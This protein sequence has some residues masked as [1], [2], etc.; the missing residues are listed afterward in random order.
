[1]AGTLGATFHDVATA[2]LEKANRLVMSEHFDEAISCIA[3]D[4]LMRSLRRGVEHVAKAANVSTLD[5]FGRLGMDQ[6]DE[7]LG[8][9]AACQV[10]ALTEW[11]A[12]AAHAG[13]LPGSSLVPDDGQPRQ[14]PA[15]LGRAA[16]TLQ[17][18]T[19]LSA[20][21]D[22]LANEVTDWMTALARCREL[23]DNAQD[24]ARG[25]RMRRLKRAIAALLVVAVAAGAGVYLTKRSLAHARVDAVIALGSCDVAQMDASDLARASSAQHDAVERERQRCE[26]EREQARLAQEVQQRADEKRKA[27]ERE[28]RRR[29]EACTRLGRNFANGSLDDVD[30]KLIGE[31]RPLFDRLASGRL[32]VNDVAAG[33]EPPCPDT[34]TGKALRLAYAR[35]VLVSVQQWLRRVTPSR[36]ACSA[37]VEHK[38]ALSAH[39]LALLAGHIE[40]LSKRAVM[41]GKEPDVRRF[42]TLCTLATQIADS[43]GGNCE[44]VQKL[45]E[46]L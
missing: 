36:D 21:L 10:T 13:G 34:E 38:M 33:F 26:D 46:K 23:I 11:R 24:L 3:R 22:A 27:I 28:K 6:L 5:V 42:S 39:G 43:A 32:T 30:A 15:N 12:Y 44:A 35:G 45:A 18:E 20:S 19:E 40:V 9:L 8:N 17:T 31:R 41:T 4:E 37:L 7:Q 2:P 16:A 25:R 14:L 29:D 1:M